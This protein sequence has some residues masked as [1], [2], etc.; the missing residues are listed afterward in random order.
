MFD[1]MMLPAELRIKIY[2][3]ALVRGVIR[4]VS[5]AHPFGAM[6]RNRNKRLQVFYEEINP[7]KSE[8]LRSRRTE[9]ESVK[10]TAGEEVGED[11]SWSYAIQPNESPPLVNIFLTSRRVYSEAWPIFYER[12]AFAFTTPQ[13]CEVSVCMCLRFLYDRP[14]HA[15]QYIRELHLNMGT[16]PHQPFRH[17]INSSGWPLLFDELKRYVSIRVLVLYIRGRLDDAAGNYRWSELPWK[18]W[19]YT[20]ADLRPLQELHFDIAS[21]STNEE[22]INFVK[23]M[24]SKMVAG[25]DQMGT[26]G[27][28]LGRRRLPGMHWSCNTLSTSSNVPNMEENYRHYKP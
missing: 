19:I 5:T 22:N 6:S 28:T 18:E 4:I 8:S 17:R 23:Q 9:F 1:L 27:F 14:Y 20:I 26:E 24:R 16:V 11:F 7:G 21:Q 25:G 12:N 13:E 10:N 3:Y 2:E 15:L